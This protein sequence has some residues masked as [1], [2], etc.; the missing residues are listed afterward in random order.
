MVFDMGVNAG[1]GRSI[2]L[3]QSAVGVP[4]D[5][6]LGPI[7]MKAV[8]AA[9]PVE[10]IDRFSAEKE[11]FYRSLDSFKTYGTGWLNRVAQVKVK[12]TSMLA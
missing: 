12:S 6:G 7:S 3:L 9:D 4:A 8:L 5:G 11:A 10:L 2:K 1:P